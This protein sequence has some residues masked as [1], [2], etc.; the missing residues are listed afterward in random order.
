MILIKKYKAL[1]VI[2]YESVEKARMEYEKRIND[3]CTYKTGV[4]INPMLRGLRQSKSY[5]VFVVNN[6]ELDMMQET[7]EENA[8]II[9]NMLRKVPAVGRKQYFHTVLIE[10]I[11]S[12]NE[13]EGVRST[14]KEIDDA[15]VSIQ[16]NDTKNERFTGIVKSY[17]SLFYDQ[18]SPIKDVKEIR[19]IYD[20]MV[21]DEIDQENKLDGELF[22]A[23]PVVIQGDKNQVLH[24]GDSHESSIIENLGLFLDLMNSESYPYLIKIMIGHYFF[25]YIHPFYDGN[26]RVGRYIACKYLAQK[27]DPLTAISFSFMI[28]SKKNKYYEAFAETSDPNNYGE[29]TMFVFQMLKIVREGQKRL[30]EDLAKKIQLLNKA[31]YVLGELNIN[32]DD[33]GVLYLL[34][35]SWSFEKPIFDMQIS[36]QLKISDYRTRKSL[37]NLIELNYI[38][39]ISKRPSRHRITKETQQ[40]IVDAPTE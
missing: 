4:E 22:R 2:K 36:K 34:F 10:E 29:A 8:A 21:E 30:I 27:L 12:T 23:R 37:A 28:S 19:F 32:K 20:Q 24:R 26:G 1:R 17:Q 7:I 13:I 25:E 16:N 33:K 15:I 14:R 11:Q 38:E 31:K 35:Q 40:R 3:Y 39:K 9:N 6:I 18:F 5:E